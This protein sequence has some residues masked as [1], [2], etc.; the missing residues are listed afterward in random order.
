MPAAVI[1]TRSREG[2]V[3]DSQPE[4]RHNKRRGTHYH[5]QLRLLDKGR[6]TKELVVCYVLCLGSILFVEGRVLRD[7]QGALGSGS[8]LWPV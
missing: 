1:S 8:L 6:A 2:K 7:S 4:L 3:F 5:A